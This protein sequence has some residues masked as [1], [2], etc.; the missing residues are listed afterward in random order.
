LLRMTLAN[1]DGWPELAGF[2]DRAVPD[3]AFPHRNAGPAS[4]PGAGR[5][6]GR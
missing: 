3:V 6:G 1:G 2:L 5:G 4:A